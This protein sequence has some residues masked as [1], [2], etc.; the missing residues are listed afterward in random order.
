MSG[1]STE[2]STLSIPITQMRGG[3]DLLEYSRTSCNWK[4]P[5]GTK[6]CPNFYNPSKTNFTRPTESNAAQLGGKPGWTPINPVC[7]AALV[8]VAAIMRIRPRLK[9]AAFSFEGVCL[10]LCV[11]NTFLFFTFLTFICPL[12]RQVSTLGRLS[13][14]AH[15]CSGRQTC[16]SVAFSVDTGRQRCVEVVCPPVERSPWWV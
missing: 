5:N 11:W 6:N 10:C 9:N 1:S 3:A 16:C 15:G 7:Q 13:N 12:N 2:P 4:P 8:R 14:S